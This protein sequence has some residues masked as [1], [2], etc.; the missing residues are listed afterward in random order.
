MR[1]VSRRT[2]EEYWEGHADAEKPLLA[3][4][5]IAKRAAWS[6]FAEVR[7]Q[8]PQTDL[9]VSDSGRKL[10]FN[11][12]SNHYRL[13]CLVRFDRQALYVLWIGTHAEYDRLDVKAL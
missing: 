5:A 8:L 12:R 2:L 10:V 4:Y 1:V 13:V 3:W 11:I 7:A 9:V 6:D